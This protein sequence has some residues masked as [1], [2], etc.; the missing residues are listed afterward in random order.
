MSIY[1][2]AK[3]VAKDAHQ[4]IG[5]VRKYSGKPYYHHPLAV[6]ELV[7]LVTDNENVLAAAA[8]HDVLEDVTPFNKKYNKDF[9]EKEFGSEVLNLV[10]ELTNQY[11]K[12][13]YPDL[14]R[15]SRKFLESQRIS[16]ISEKA[17]IIKRAD[18]HHNSQEMPSDSKFCKLWLEEKKEIE[19]SIGSWSDFLKQC[20]EIQSSFD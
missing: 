2:K 17:K 4:S 12:S 1:E 20:V 8:L 15:K 14:N 18:L 10:I 19:K 9:I 3:K 11:E 5:H 6:A 13:A 7:S 16:K